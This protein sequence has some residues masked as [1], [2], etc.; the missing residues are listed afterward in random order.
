[1][2]DLS[3]QESMRDQ[4]TP[5]TTLEKIIASDKPNMLDIAGD[6]LPF[7][8]DTTDVGNPT[9]D[10]RVVSEELGITGFGKPNIR[11]VAGNELVG[12][13]APSTGGITTIDKPNIR[14]IAG[15]STTV[16][17]SIS[18]EDL[19]K[20]SNIGDFQITGAPDLTNQTGI[21]NAPPSIGLAQDPDVEDPFDGKY[22]PSFEEKKAAEGILEGLLD[23]ALDFS[24]SDIAKMGTNAITNK[25]LKT[26]GFSDPFSFLGTMGIN[27]FKN[28]QVQKEIEK[29]IASAK[30][31]KEIREIQKNL[32]K[33]EDDINKNASNND[34][35]TGSSIVNPNST[36][37]KKQGY[38]GGTPNPHTST[39]WSGS[40][41]KAS[42]KSSSNTGTPTGGGGKGGGADSG[43]KKGGTSSTSSGLGNLGFSDI[44]LKD[45]I[46]LVGKSKSDINIYNFTYL[47][48]PTVYQGV[49]AHEVPWASVKHDSGYLMVDYNKIDVDFKSIR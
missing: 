21:L 48:D 45:N 33:K 16:D 31:R 25:A 28:I 36:F 35:K 32:D 2:N 22:S 44:R 27:K 6:S 40:S 20:P 15:P 18:I 1:M 41:K 38:T 30:T 10:P 46:E 47:N 5:T 29:Q 11:D 43:G 49:M 42:D 17:E 12:T 23:K 8:F 7:N 9:N 34:S 19:S 4:I 14:D 26:L 37:G 3:G 39:G 24:L 13:I